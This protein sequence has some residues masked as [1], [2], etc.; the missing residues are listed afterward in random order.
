[1]LLK[2]VLYNY[3]DGPFT[4]ISPITNRQVLI[5]SETGAFSALVKKIE[6]QKKIND[7]LKAADSE[8]NLRIQELEV[9]NQLYFI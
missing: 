5:L 3:Q 4:A 2:Y 8:C 7:G 9:N 1:M 6:I